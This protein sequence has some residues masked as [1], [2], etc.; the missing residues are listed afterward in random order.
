MT[1]FRIQWTS[2]TVRQRWPR[3]SSTQTSSVLLCPQPEETNTPE[4]APRRAKCVKCKFFIRLVFILVK[5]IVVSSN[6]SLSFVISINCDGCNEF[7]EV[8]RSHF[9]NLFLFYR[10]VHF[11]SILSPVHLSRAFRQLK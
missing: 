4:K 5:L 6:N 10:F 9:H 2:T 1:R 11:I 3:C 8:K 7:A